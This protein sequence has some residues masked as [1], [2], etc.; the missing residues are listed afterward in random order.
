[1]EEGEATRFSFAQRLSS[2]QRISRGLDRLTKEAAMSDGG[3]LADW[4]GLTAA[5]SAAY[6]FMIHEEEGHEPGYPQGSENP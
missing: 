3:K 2:A 4:A 6:P 1:M 5:R